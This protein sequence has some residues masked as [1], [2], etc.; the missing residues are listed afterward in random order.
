MRHSHAAPDTDTLM[1]L[2]HET[3]QMIHGGQAAGPASR[4][5]APSIQRGSTVLLADSKQFSA[6]TTPTYGRGGLATQDALRTAL[7]ALEHA[8]DVQLYP[9][10]LAALT[11]AI[12]AL[13]GAGDEVLAVDTIY[14]PT[15]RFL[16]G[17]MARFGVTTVVDATGGAP[18]GCGSQTRGMPGRRLSRAARSDGSAAMPRP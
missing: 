6:A 18:R 3:T 5:P 2:R 10:G 1:P 4:T 8:E 7:C 15:R 9:S 17:T 11:G 14:N 12:Q 16:A 13:T